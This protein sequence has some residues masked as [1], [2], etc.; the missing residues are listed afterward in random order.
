MEGI[1]KSAESTLPQE[2]KHQIS[3]EVLPNKPESNQYVLKYFSIHPN[4]L[5]N[6]KEIQT[7]SDWA[8][9]DGAS[10]G[11]GLMNIKELEQ[12]LGYTGDDERVTKI[13]NYVTVLNNI[14]STKKSRD[15]EVDVVKTR[16]DRDISLKKEQTIKEITELEAKLEQAKRNL[17][18][19]DDSHRVHLTEQTRIIR[20]KYK[21]QLKDLENIAKSYK[22]RK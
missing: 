9:R 13:F 20:D 6:K 16:I 22:R 5:Y 7:I 17:K 14:E 8:Y 15:T 1:A 18:K 12:K 3:S 21:S 11:E 19:A 2:F 4:S 10:P